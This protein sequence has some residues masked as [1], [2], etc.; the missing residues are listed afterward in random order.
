[1]ALLYG[2]G[3][4]LVAIFIAAIRIGD[5]LEEIRIELEERKKEN[6]ESY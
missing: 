4:V 2:I 6:A 5:T 1:M 3:L